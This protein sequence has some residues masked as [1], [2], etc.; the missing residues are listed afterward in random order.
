[1]NQKAV[2]FT[3]GNLAGWSFITMCMPLDL[4]KTKL[5]LNTRL[6][7]DNMK[8]LIQE[9]G[10]FFRTFYSGA[11]SMYLFFGLAT[12]LE[13]TVFESSLFSSKGFNLPVGFTLFGSGFLAGATSS[14][15][16]TPIEYSKIQSQTQHCKSE[17]G[18][19]RRL[20]NIIR[21]EK[22]RGLRNMYTGLSYTI[23]R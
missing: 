23:M 9:K 16:Y 6:S 14:F 15:I 2:D 3:A 18:S 12:A 10:G 17:M 4:L 1:M 7:I 22:M 5:Q 19:A 21:K 13:L 8:I 11:S 20:L